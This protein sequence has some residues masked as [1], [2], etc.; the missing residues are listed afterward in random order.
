MTN[1]FIALVNK[2][3]LEETNFNKRILVF[4]LNL[5]EKKYY[6]NEEEREEEK[7]KEAFIEF[8]YFKE[9]N[10][11]NKEPIKNTIYQESIL[12]KQIEKGL[13]FQ[14]YLPNQEE[15]E[16]SE[17]E[18][19]ENERSEEERSEEEEENNKKKYIQSFE[20]SFKCALQIKI[21]NE[22]VNSTFY[23][24]TNGIRVYLSEKLYYNSDYSKLVQFFNTKKKDILLVNEMELYNIQIRKSDLDTLISYSMVSSVCISA[25][26][27][28]V[29]KENYLDNCHLFDTDFYSILNN[30]GDVTKYTRNRKTK[31]TLINIFE[32]EVLLFLVYDKLVLH[33]CLIVVLIKQKIIYVLDS[34]HFDQQKSVSLIQG[35]LIQESTNLGHSPINFNNWN[36]NYGDETRGIPKQSNFID[37]GIYCCLF[38]NFIVNYV[39]NTPLLKEINFGLLF[40]NLIQPQFIPKVRLQIHNDII[41]KK[42]FSN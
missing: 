9:N 38:V 10:N 26:C 14:V 20:F 34:L 13:I 3:K 42:I 15:D 7:T 29:V 1:E 12:V 16:R 35:Y 17:D 18:R 21:N 28:L 33:Y 37:C 30:N 36:I 19:S 23:K 40:K 4:I 31:Q 24:V 2:N 8:T 41:N 22:I 5:V 27:N 11:D 6:K 25:Y 39:K 32:K